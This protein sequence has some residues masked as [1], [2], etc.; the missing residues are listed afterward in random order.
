MPILRRKTLLLIL[1][2]ILLFIGGAALYLRTPL[3]FRHLAYVIE[4]KYG[5]SVHADSVAYSP[6]MKAR[7][8]NLQVADNKENGFR[9]I[10]KDVNVESKFSAA[11]KGEVEKIILNEPKV[12]IRIGEKKDTETDL[13]F[14]KKIP[15][16]HLLAIRKGEFKLIFGAA[17]YELKFREINLDV[18]KFSPLTGGTAD[19]RG[20]IEIT[21]RES[22]GAAAQG[23]CTGSMKL[24]GLFPNPVGTGVLEISLNSGVFKTT[25]LENAKLCLSVKFEK[26]RITITRINISADSLILRNTAV[27]KSKIRNLLLNTS[28]TYELKSK[29]LAVDRFQF[30]ISSLGI[31]SGY[32][33]GVMKDAFPWKASINA[34]D[35][36]FKT[37]FIYLKPFIEESGGDKWSIQGKGTLKS[38]MEGTF[39]GREPSLSGKAVLQFQ[40]GG[41]NSA[42]GTKAAQGME[43]SMVLKFSIPL[44][45]QKTSIKMHTDIFPGEYLFGTYYKDFA[46]DRLK[47]SSDADISFSTEQQFDFRGKLNFFDTGQYT[48][49][50]SIGKN[51]WN[52]SFIGKDIS[53]RKLLSVLF[54]DYIQQNYTP[55]KNIDVTGELNAALKV[56]AEG[57]KYSLNGDIHADKMSVSIP[58]KTLKVSNITVDLPF[59]LSKLSMAP[60]LEEQSVSGKI[61][62]ERLERGILEINGINIPITSSNNAF[63]VSENL[64]IPLY[65]GKLRILQCAVLDILSPLRKFYFAAKIDNLDM[66]ALMDDLTGIQLPGVVEARFPMIA[67]EDGKWVT[68]GATELKI[69]GGTIEA[70][71]VHA[72]NLL[73]SSRSMGGDITFSDIDLGKITDSVKIGK[74]KG[75]IQGSIKGLEIE[76]GQPSYFVL[77]IDSVKKK[78][79]EQM[80]SV[81]AIENISIVGTGS[82][83]VGAIL[84]SG[85]NRFFKEYPYSRIGI[86]CTLENDNFRLN[87]KINEGNNE[88]FI[89][90][91][92]FRG[93]DVINRDPDNTVSFNDMQERIGRIFKKSGE[94]PTFTTSMN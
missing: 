69:F 63:A 3:F 28:M 57:E 50:G 14:I 41:F 13:S 88:Y 85:I 58:E 70:N 66:G 78:G 29:T 21:G 84:R 26:E 77:D 82:G 5:L 76:Y 4:Y 90:K 91:S 6:V 31:L 75:I 44:D 49:T 36:D 94:E 86:K 52:F 11:V 73:S 12:Q 48:Y 54:Y 20:L 53:N 56:E 72:K 2:A 60:L 55:L 74:I 39:K 37:L 42:D 59:K 62:I 65:G 87:G 1:P 68:K 89:R 32:Y 34:T 23:Q 7:M 19:F 81:D 24:T 45:S 64:E 46:R 15:P 80:I 47:I 16:V 35:I 27:S 83:A 8:S 10:S 25:S 33:R 9:F 22:T 71:N 40:K 38:E 43:G 18:T 30:E 93:L 92:L 67:H 51:K 61:F 17:D 79:V